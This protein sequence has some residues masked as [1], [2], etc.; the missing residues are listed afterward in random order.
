M[1]RHNK[2]YSNHCHCHLSFRGGITPH[3]YLG[4][5][6][7]FVIGGFFLIREITNKIQGEK[8]NYWS[9]IF[10]KIVRLW[11]LIILCSAV[12]MGLGYYLML[13]DD[14]EN[15][16]Q[17]VVASSFFLN[18]M[19]QCI[20]TRNY[21]DIVNLYK[22]LMHLWYIGLLMQLYV[23]FPLVYLI[24]WK[25]GK[26]STKAL[27]ITTIIISISSLIL[28]LLP[29]FSSAW[30]FYLL[31]FRLF[32]LST[33][34]LLVFYSPA[35]K[36][37][38]AIG[39][40][41][42]LIFLLVLCSRVKFISGSIMLILT[43][44]SVLMLL[45][46][47]NDVNFNIIDGKPL[48]LL[49]IIGK[50]SYSI[51]IWHQMIVAFLFYSIFPDQNVVSFLVFVIM[52]TIVSVISYRFIECP[53]GRCVADKRKESIAIITSLIFA[54]IL[55][56]IAFCVYL[57]AGV[58]RDI[59]EL[60]IDKDNVHRNMHAEYCDRPYAWDRD[61]TTDTIR[62][63]VVGDSFGRDWAN[64]LYEYNQDM[65]I[66]Y[67]FYTK[68]HMNEIKERIES[69][70]K[71]FYVLSGINGISEEVVDIVPD[72]KLFIVGPKNFGKSNGIVYA[73][74]GNDDY[75][76]ITVEANA[77]IVKYDELLQQRFGKHYISMMVPVMSDETHVRV[78]T[79]DNKYI[80]QD[81]RHLTQA[82]A[83]YYSRIIGIDSILGIE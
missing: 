23:F 69:S 26:K 80:S 54:G 47:I 52:T 36:R 71:V 82:G 56:G 55:V 73:Q 62:I 19:L 24:A 15:L 3:G 63:L 25:I 58:V 60:N 30:K 64:V 28:F 8:F 66:S 40:C 74:R 39:I 5:D 81:C 59:P 31:P 11:P 70:D 75:F 35:I 76:E 1:D 41:A 9:F 77:E 7:F 68:G 27:G 65:D 43:V 10:R 51:Y 12:S 22:P 72:D 48:K 57:H 38:K 29:V 45:V 53:L 16:A 78:F 79:D 6:A 37:K 21:W 42:L 61:F 33:G 34:G 32:E 83:Q 4:V 67:R 13:P 14:Y 46:C 2:G 20:T 18:N 17:S 44:V 49:A 50:S